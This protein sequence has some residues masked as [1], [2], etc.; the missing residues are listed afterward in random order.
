MIDKNFFASNW[1][2]ISRK[3]PL[4]CGL[5]TLNAELTIYAVLKQAHKQFDYVVITDDGSTDATKEEIAKCVNDFSIQNLLFVDASKINPWNDE[6]NVKRP[7][8]HHV[9]RHDGKTH[10][11]A[12]WKSYTFIKENFPNSIYVSLEDDVV[13]EDSVRWR[14]YDRISKWKEPHTDCEFFNVTSVLDDDHVLMGMLPD[15]RGLP[16]IVQRH[17]YNNGGD[18]TLSALWTGGDLQIGPDPM[19]PFGACIYP[20]LQKNQTGKKG[21]DGERSFGFHM[22]NYRTSKNGTTYANTR[23]ICRI[24]DLP[25]ASRETNWDIVRNS[26]FRQRFKLTL[27]DNKYVQELM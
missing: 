3:L 27:R 24:D 15:G 10:A 21:Q 1:E 9:P 26:Q 20:W 17:P 14:I 13:L 6:A 22:L 7:G 4:I 2:E 8:D 16:G 12:Q 23:E 25:E 19:Y 18:W 5:K 11:K